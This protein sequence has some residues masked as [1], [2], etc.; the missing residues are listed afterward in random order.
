MFKN[1]PDIKIS[2]NEL[3]TVEHWSYLTQMQYIYQDY[4]TNNLQLV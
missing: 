3:I 4:A 1:N 2:E